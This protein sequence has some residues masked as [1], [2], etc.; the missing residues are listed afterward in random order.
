MTGALW[1]V[2]ASGIF[3]LAVA[4]YTKRSEKRA[5]IESASA[6]AKVDERGQLTEEWD[7]IRRTL[8]EELDHCTAALHAEQAARREAEQ[9]AARMTAERDHALE[10]LEET[11]QLGIEH[12]GVHPEENL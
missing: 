5:Q 8:R 7:L 3:S 11:Y 10:A 1:A 2:V 9:R 6:T 4:V 12:R